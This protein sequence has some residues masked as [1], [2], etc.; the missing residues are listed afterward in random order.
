[1]PNDNVTDLPS[2]DAG[3]FDTDSM[4]DAIGAG[5]GLGLEEPEPTPEANPTG[6]SEAP[7][8]PADKPT[9]TPA[10]EVKTPPSPDTAPASAPAG[11]P[12]ISAE[13]P[14]NQWRPTAAAHWQ[15]LPQEVREEIAKREQDMFNGIE[16]YKKDAGLGKAFLDIVKPYEGFLQQTGE[17]VGKL[18]SDLMGVHFTLSVGTQEQKL[19]LLKS[20]ASHFKVDLG[21]LAPAD[22]E[23]APY[24]DPQVKALR[25]EINALKS[26]QANADRQQQAQ[27]Q[28]A[29]TAR[30]AELA[31]EIDAFAADP[32]NPDFDLL[33]PEITNLLRMGHN[34]REAYDKAVWLNPVT[35]EKALQ[36]AAAERAEAERKAKAEAAAKAASLAKA[37][38]KPTAKNAS[39]AAALESMDDT[40][41]GA[42]AKIMG[43]A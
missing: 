24:E 11:R 7:T 3:G 20:I 34:L 41:K 4:V 36:S 10:P 22:P 1:M 5:L 16:G 35:R 19:D 28:Q 15:A 13:A 17:D 30:R 38:V 14:P 21:G 32:K 26:H 2:G 37:N 43:Q 40:L 29:A 6:D 12:V 23:F 18:T 25:D 39:A 27:A 33:A 42:Y 9:P 8:P 31:A